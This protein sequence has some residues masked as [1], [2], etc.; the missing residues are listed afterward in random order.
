MPQDIAIIVG[1]ICLVFA[2]F[3]G[4]LFWADRRTSKLP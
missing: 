2:A 1:A 3:A 4:V